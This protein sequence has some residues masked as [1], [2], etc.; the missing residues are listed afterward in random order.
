MGNAG[1]PGVG[2]TNANLVFSNA[3]SGTTNGSVILPAIGQIPSTNIYYPTNYNLN[4]YTSQASGGLPAANGTPAPNAHGSTG[5]G[6]N[7]SVFN[8]INPNGT[9]SLY[10]FDT[11]GNRGG[12]I[13][14][15]WQLSI[16]T[17]P[18][19]NT[20]TNNY[21]TLENVP[22]NILIPVGDA[23]PANTA[24]TVSNYVTPAGFSTVTTITIANSNNVPITNN[25]VANLAIL[26]ITPTPYQFGT[27]NIQITA[28][29]A[30]GVQSVTNILFTVV[31][32]PQPPLILITNTTFSTPAAV[33][34][35]GIL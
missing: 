25:G 28:T 33:P 2:L 8:G 35:S 29:D 6:T 14:G 30:S 21:S 32:N 4:A 3:I 13:F 31:S 23:E 16:F 34:I 5:Y 11:N 9:W 20:A 15:G 1:G 24:L 12:A 22:T 10:A 7:M 26:A 27:N 19:I 17:A 18:N